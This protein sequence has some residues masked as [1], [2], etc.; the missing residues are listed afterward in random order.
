MTKRKTTKQ[1]DQEQQQEQRD[2]DAILDER[3]DLR[4]LFPPDYSPDISV[5]RDGSVEVMFKLT[6][7]QARNLASLL[8]E[9]SL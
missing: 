6:T 2:R 4:R 1:F 9:H 5:C 8:K 3:L 7:A